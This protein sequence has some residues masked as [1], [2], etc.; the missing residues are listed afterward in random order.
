MDFET[1][2]SPNTAYTVL[3]HTGTES[4]REEIVPV[5]CPV[6]EPIAPERE[7]CEFTGWYCD[8]A[9]TQEYVFTAPVNR[10]LCLYA[11]WKRKSCYVR[12]LAGS[13]ADSTTQEIAYGST[14]VEPDISFPG[15]VL[16]GWYTEETCVN[17]YNFNT[18]VTRNLLLYAKWRQC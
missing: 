9:L 12:L 13:M 14:A 10:S 16:E 4:Y 18:K 6:L 1:G 2:S 11:G 3:F 15:Y 8:E 5:G 7:G 17:R